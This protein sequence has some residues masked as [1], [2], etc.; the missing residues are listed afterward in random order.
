MPKRRAVESLVREL[1]EAMVEG[2]SGSCNLRDVQRTLEDACVSLLYAETGGNMSKMAERAG[3]S[4]SMIY[5]LYHRAGNLAKKGAAGAGS[6]KAKAK[7][8]SAKKASRKR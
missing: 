5:V 3:I 8:K 7:R 4:R 1:A 2:E 6:K